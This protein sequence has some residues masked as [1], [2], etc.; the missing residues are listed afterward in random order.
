MGTLIFS[1]F[2]FPR[3]PERLLGLP[4]TGVVDVWALGCVAFE[5][6]TG[7]V[8]YPGDSDYQMV[9]ITV[10]YHGRIY[11]LFCLSFGL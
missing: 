10:I 5:L 1:Y 2:S 3:P 9:G 4:L 7:H 6:F 11:I 8:L